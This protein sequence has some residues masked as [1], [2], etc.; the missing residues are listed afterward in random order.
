MPAPRHSA[1]FPPPPEDLSFGEVRLR[2]ERIVPADAAHGFAPYYHFQ[3]LDKTGAA[4]G[5]INFRLG[6]TEHLMVCAG[7]IGFRVEEA[8]R[9]RG[10]A[11]Q[12]C[13]ALAPFVRSIY[14]SVIV[15]TNPDNRASIRTIENLGAEFLGVIDV[16]PHDPGYAKGARVKRRYR[17]MP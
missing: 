6:E 3:I 12:A 8:F 15:T 7:H 5:H 9:G 1:E 16:P 10:Y 11:E 2:F 14:E 4:A 17:W 13:R